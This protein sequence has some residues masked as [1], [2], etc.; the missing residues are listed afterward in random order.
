MTE[1]ALFDEAAA[2]PKL[3]DAETTRALERCLVRKHHK[4]SRSNGGGQ[5]VF[6]LHVRSNAGFLDV[7]GREFDAVAMHAWQSK[8]HII[9]IFEIKASRSDLRRELADPS[10]SEAAKAVGDRFWLVTPKGLSDGII[11]PDWWGVLEAT[12]TFSALRTVKRAP[13]LSAPIGWRNPG[14]ALDR[15]FVVALF[16]AEA[17]LLGKVRRSVATAHYIEANA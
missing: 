3:T 7:H 1:P 5:Y 15:S 8:G 10:K 14:R 2:L 12:T 9:D 4:A 17:E 11:L 6:G 16:Q 13:L